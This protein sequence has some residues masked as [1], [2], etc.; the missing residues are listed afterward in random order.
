MIGGIAIAGPDRSPVTEQLLRQAAG[1][2]PA[3]PRSVVVTDG[4]V[5]LYASAESGAL[6]ARADAW[7]A[8]D[9]DL[10]NLPELQRRAGSSATGAE[11]LLDLYDREGAELVGRLVGAFA[12]AVWD[13][14]RRELLLA[15]DHFGIKRLHYQEQPG[16]LAF[17]T[18][19]GSLVRAPGGRAEIDPTTVYT[20]LNLGYVPAP[21]TIFA[22]VRRLP[23]AHRALASA[24][25]ISVGPYWQMTYPEHPLAESDAIASLVSH[26]EAAVGRALAPSPS[27]ET[28]AFLSGGTDSSTVVGL[29]TRLGGEPVNAFSVGFNEDHFDE[30]RY[31]G[32]AARHFG[33]SHY[34]RVLAPGDVVDSLPTLVAAFD[35]PFG[36]NSA[37]GTF[38]CAALARECG[39]SRLLA[40]DGGDEIFGGNERYRV[41][42]LYARYARIP[43]LVRSAVIEPLVGVLPAESPG[44]AGKARRY[45]QR[46]RVPNP[47]RFYWSEFFF[48]RGGADLLDGGFL[49][50]V[51]R[52]APHALLDRHFAAARASSE[53]NRLMH[54]DLQLTIGDNDLLKVTRTA[55]AA[56][57][58]VRFPLLD[59]A[60]VEFT[61]TLP[62]RFKVR[63][64]EKRYL[65]KLAFRSL[66][67]AETLAKRKHGFG[68]PT[69]VWL[70]DHPGLRAL[71]TETL[72]STR[73]RQRG[74]FAPGAIDELF[75]RHG[76]DSTAYFGDLL[77]MVLM[78]ELWHRHHVDGG[79]R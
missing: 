70:R 1:D 71:A 22:G 17:A 12:L 3:G 55:E 7:A 16:R 64:L 76:A 78:L 37:V 41:H 47:C 59:P 27:K 29:M 36:N 74:Y 20:Y 69:S 43:A 65:F 66:L 24:G 57:V 32:I 53:L 30:L 35:E 45:V 6:H 68:V 67:P 26:T 56:G 52:D 13:R 54:L 18:R 19:L 49:A 40:G 58:R 14:R 44:L 60:L 8:A 23:P 28:G 39:V 25:R 4:A 63:G 31:A 5:G 75:R 50:A 73:F 10:T 15:V 51:D 21:R 2:D 61:G 11:L 33:A 77:W 79:G 48:S 38:C 46:A 34:T 42:Q 72:R 9:L 62:A